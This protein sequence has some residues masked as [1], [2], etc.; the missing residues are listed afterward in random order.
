MKKIIFFV[1]LSLF[2]ITPAVNAQ[3]VK[4]AV[5]PTETPTPSVSDIEEN[6]ASKIASKV[7]Q[8]K[9]VEKRGVVGKV[10]EVEGTQITFEDRSGKTR[11]GD[12]DELTNFYDSSAKEI[13]IS[14]IKKNDLIL[15]VGLYNKQSRRILAREIKITVLPRFIN[16]VVVGVNE[17]EFSIEVASEKEKIAV[18]VEKITKTYSYTAD[19]EFGTSGF[20]K[21]KFRNNVVVF[22]YMDKE[23]KNRL[24]ASKIIVFSDIPPNPKIQIPID[25]VDTSITTVPSTGSGK[26][27]TPI[28]EWK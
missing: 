23:K 13:G 16:G 27:L 6:L 14:D 8:L 24:I 5:T 28:T 4:K 1:L 17:D 2:L 3:T 9:L 7:A 11:Y 15:V 26:K 19:G 21:I 18:D 22:G 25:A 20:S 12:V 10:T